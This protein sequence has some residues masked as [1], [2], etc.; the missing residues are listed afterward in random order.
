M[1]DCW[2]CLWPREVFITHP[3][4]ILGPVHGEVYLIQHYVIKVCRW[5]AT[6][7]GF[8]HHY[9]YITEILLKVVLN[10][11][12]INQIHSVRYPNNHNHDFIAELFN[13]LAF[14][15]PPGPILKK[16]KTMIE[17]R[18]LYPCKGHICMEHHFNIYSNYRV[19]VTIGIEVILLFSA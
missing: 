10:A 12:I 2:N 14:F 4:M 5:L 15:Q 7:H 1:L 16:A 6:G 17:I 9:N 11:I 18:S 8:L 3:I 13:N 19:F